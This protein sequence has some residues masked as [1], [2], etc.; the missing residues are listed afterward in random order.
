VA[1]QG[2][3]R[4]LAL[5]DG[6]YSSAPVLHRLPARCPLLARCAKNRALFAMPIRDP[7]R[8]GRRRVYGDKGPTPQE[9]LHAQDGWT[10][11]TVTVRGRTIPLTVTVTGPWLVRGAADHP[12]LL[13]VVKGVDTTIRQHRRQRAPQ[14]FLVSATA[15]GTLPY[16]LEPLLAWAWQRWEVE[17]MHRE[18][19]SSFG[20]GDAQV[21]TDASVL[22]V[23][24]WTLWSY[25]QVVLAA[26]E[27]WQLEVPPGPDRGGWYH[28]RRWSIGRAV[29]DVRQ[30]LWDLAEIRPSWS[31]TPD[32]WAE[33]DRWV[34]VQTTAV[35]G[36]RQL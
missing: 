30:E 26:A 27:H 32:A 1:D 5:A 24:A 35:R 31:R 29:Q 22:A 14:Y 7:H 28:P 36:Q 9:T 23:T 18:L 19:K 25:A 3:R 8:R 13:I 4:I 34:A 11:P 17:V 10:Q 6:A 21:W 16:P 12:V 2:T 15:E 33:M 20:W